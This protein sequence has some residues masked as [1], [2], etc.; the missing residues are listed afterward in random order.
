MWRA[1]EISMDIVL[2]ALLSALR[3]RRAR[4]YTAQQLDAIA[5]ERAIADVASGKSPALPAPR[6]PYRWW[7]YAGLW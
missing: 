6:R 4:T 7:R 3:R 1:S 2:L 5:R